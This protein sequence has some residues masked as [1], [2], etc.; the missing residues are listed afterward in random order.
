MRA[1]LATGALTV[2]VTSLIGASAVAQKK[3][4]EEVE[5]EATRILST[6]VAGRTATGVPIVNISLSY[7][8]NI[9]DLDLASRE[10]ADELERRVH[11]AAHAACK[12]ISRQHPD[13]TPDDA[14]CANAAANRAMVK[15]RDLIAQAQKGR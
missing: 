12:E 14:A 3:G 7:G 8:V 5:V 13:T 15:A 1:I 4:V 2:V 6:K 11:D 10:G 9:A